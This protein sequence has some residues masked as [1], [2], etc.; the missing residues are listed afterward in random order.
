LQLLSDFVGIVLQILS[1]LTTKSVDAD[2]RFD[3]IRAYN[4]SLPAGRRVKE[5]VYRELSPPS[6]RMPVDEV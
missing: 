1:I 5:E 2:Y 4:E 6:G 3:R